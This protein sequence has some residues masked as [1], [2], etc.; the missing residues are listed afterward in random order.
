M[1]RKLYYIHYLVKALTIFA[2]STCGTTVMTVD[3]MQITEH[4][5]RTTKS[6]ASH[7]L[8]RSS[9]TATLDIGS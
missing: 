1:P 3:A 9:I 2:L 6:R 5:Y 8:E 7:V 4:A